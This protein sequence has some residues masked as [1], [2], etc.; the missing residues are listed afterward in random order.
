MCHLRS[1]DVMV[2]VAAWDHDTS[3]YAEDEEGV[4]WYEKEDHKIGPV[5]PVF[6]VGEGAATKL[7][8]VVK[9]LQIDTILSIGD[10]NEVEYIY[11]VKSLE[12]KNLEW[13]NILNNGS[14]PINENK[15][16][17]IDSIDYH[18]LLNE[19]TEEEFNRLNVP[20]SKYSLQRWGSVFSNEPPKT[21]NEKFGI[22][23][24]A[25]NNNQ[26]NLGCFIKAIAILNTTIDMKSD[27][28][29]YLHT[30]LY[31][32]GD[33][34]IEGLIEREGV[35]EI[36]DLPDE[37][38]GI[39]DGLSD[40]DFKNKINN[41]NLIVDCSCQS[42][43]GIS[44]LDGMALGLIPLVSRVG[45]LK[46]I[47]KELSKISTDINQFSINGLDFVASD[48][49]EFFIA[50][51]AELAI[52]MKKMYRHWNESSTSRLSSC[53]QKISASYNMFSFLENTCKIIKDFKLNNSNLVVETF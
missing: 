39:N 45:I 31:D 26:S 52:N 25:K 41:Y 32:N 3:W 27:I 35:S 1:N 24:I 21:K 7:Y 51:D 30:D 10:F 4:C 50:S 29:V 53:A 42:S 48:E 36:I 34:D 14:V 2:A 46:Q 47:D 9:K 17:L 38:I 18:I 28:N 22:A 15:K 23:C 33:Y 20:E 5:Y 49:K 6:N 16:E 40:S 13:I 12:K 44:V 11:A 43:T 19:A 8:D 37:F